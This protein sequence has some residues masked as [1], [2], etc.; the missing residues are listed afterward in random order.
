MLEK[1]KAIEEKYEELTKLL[2]DPEILSKLTLDNGISRITVSGEFLYTA[3]TTNGIKTYDISQLRNPRE[4]YQ[5]TPEN[6]YIYNLKINGDIAYLA[7]GIYG[8]E[9]V[10]L[11][12]KSDPQS[13][14]E[15]NFE[16]D[17][18]DLLIHDSLLFLAVEGI[19]AAGFVR[20]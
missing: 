16:K 5:F 3:S 1:L 8:L 15:L 12:D 9:I 20:N 2:M 7:K 6:N 18:H 14:I 11:S 10:D 17:V 4:S 19:V 13:I